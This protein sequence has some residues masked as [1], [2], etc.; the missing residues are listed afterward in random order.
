[1]SIKLGSLRVSRAAMLAASVIAAAALAAC[2]KE[3]QSL[4]DYI[5]AIC[6]ADFRGASREEMPFLTD[7]VAAMSKMMVD[8]GIKP[9][10][11]ID[12]DFVA[13]MVPHH[14]GAI[15]MAQAE[16]R[17]GNNETLRRMAQEIIVTQQQEIAAMR[18]A[19]NQLMPSSAP[20]LSRESSTVGD[21]ARSTSP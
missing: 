10:G 2:S 13:M 5:S 4:A 18:H 6:A 14:Q 19:L 21:D 17:Y 1:M 3:T 12:R 7:N 9:S 8:M 16:L 11:E 20:A 15:D